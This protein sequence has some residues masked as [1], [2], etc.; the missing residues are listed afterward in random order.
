M[1][2]ECEKKNDAAIWG[3][4]YVIGR[5]RKS[6]PK[7][8]DLIGTGGR[9]RRITG[10]RSV[11]VMGAC[12]KKLYMISYCKTFLGGGLRCS[13]TQ[14]RKQSHLSAVDEGNHKNMIKFVQL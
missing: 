13:Y 9:A 5:V 6:R 2:G 10:F 7:Q 8:L 12:M 14:D 1:A 4:V 11:S 3:I